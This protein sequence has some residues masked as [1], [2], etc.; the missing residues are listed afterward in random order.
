MIEGDDGTGFRQLTNKD[1]VHYAIGKSELTQLELELT[2][3]LE[4]VIQQREDVLAKVP[5]LPCAQCPA[6]ARLL[7]SD[8]DEQL[9]EMVGTTAWE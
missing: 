7:P 1:L 5:S 6:F 2:L 8:I 3:R 9:G 4:Q